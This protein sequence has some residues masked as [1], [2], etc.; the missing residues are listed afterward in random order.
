M[1]LEESLGVFV[2]L[3]SDKVLVS[4]KSSGE[5]CSRNERLSAS[6]IWGFES[7]ERCSW[8]AADH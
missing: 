3:I 7:F 6:N 1:L 8:R 5:W 4:A 2:M